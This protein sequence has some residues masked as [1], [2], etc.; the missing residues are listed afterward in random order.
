MNSN[1][2]GKKTKE[3]QF[4]HAK[5]NAVSALGKLLRYQNQNCDTNVLLPGFV[6]LLPLKNDLDEAKTTNEFFAQILTDNFLAVV[7]D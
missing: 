1:V 4:Q 5:D 7:G 6:S 2:K 3:K